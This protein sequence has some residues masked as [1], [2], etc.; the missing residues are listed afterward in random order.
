MVDTKFKKGNIPHN[1]GKTKENYEPQKKSS[2]SRERKDINEKEEY[3]LNLY[4][5][6]NKSQFEISKILGCD[7]VVINRILKNNNIELRPQSYY[8]KGKESLKKGKNYNELYGKDR[9]SKYK[10]IIKEK[11]KEQ[12]FTEEQ[13]KRRGISVSKNAK[14]NPNFGMKGKHQTKEQI[15]KMSIRNSGEKNYFW[16]VGK[17]FEP[18]DKYF[19]TRFKR[20]IRKRDNYVCMNCGIHCEK[21]NRALSIHHINYDKL[22]T[23]PENCI[24]LCNVCH[25]LTQINREYWIKLFYNKMSNLYGYKYSNDNKIILEVNND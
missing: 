9:A 2:E 17:S 16:D 19:N 13:T 10:E 1:K 12:I 25:S 5:N 3:I 11:R 15:E 24:S 8:L 18:Y 21:L 6:K 7:F 14:N 23:I 20:E 22:L 4:L